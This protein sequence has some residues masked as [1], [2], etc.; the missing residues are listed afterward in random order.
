MFFDSYFFGFPAPRP[1]GLA[2]PGSSPYNRGVSKRI[3]GGV[4]TQLNPFGPQWPAG[5]SAEAPPIGQQVQ[6]TLFGKPKPL[7]LDLAQHPQLADILAVLRRYLRKM[8]RMAGDDEGDY[9]LTLADGVLAM[10]DANGLIYVGA[11]FVSAFRNRPEVLVGAIAHEVGHRPKRW[12]QY[13]V[14]RDLTPKE[15]EYIAR[16]EE[17]R[18]DIF[19]GK[20]L[21]ELGFDCEPLCELL[22]RVEDGDRPHREYFPAR[23]RARIIRDAH[24]GRAYRAENRR[25]IFPGFDRMTAPKGDLGEY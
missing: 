12:S 7:V 19:A 15:I 24:A 13:Q 1:V 20:A 4:S 3:E 17:T 2:E 18:A 5:K 22:L 8:A 25:K 6:Q 21:A 9:A 23:D 14:R 10:I 16:H 11:G